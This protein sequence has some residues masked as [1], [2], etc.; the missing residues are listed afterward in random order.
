MRP[1]VLIII[2]SHIIG[3]PG[4]GL[5]Q[6]LKYASPDRFNYVLCN[7]NVANYKGEFEF[8]KQAE[9]NGINIELI[10]QKYMFDPG[11]IWQAYKLIKDNDINIIQTHGYK[12]HII[13]FI[14]SIIL[15]I[16][17][18]A[19]VHG[20]TYE[21]KKIR[22]YNKLELFLLRYPHAVITV[23]PVLYK[24]LV[25]RRGERRTTKMILNAIDEYD[26]RGSITKKNI[27]INNNLSQ[28]DFVIGVFGRLSPEK[29]H[30]YL[31]E[32][33]AIC[34]DKYPEIRLLILGDG[35]EK[36]NLI[37]LTQRHGLDKIVIFCGHKS[38][39]RDYYDAINLLILP[40][41]TE[42]VPNVVLEAMSLCKPVIATDVGGVSE[43]ITDG[44]NGWIIKPGDANAIVNILDKILYAK[45]DI[46]SVGIKARDSLYPKFSTKKR[47]DDIIQIYEETL[48]INNN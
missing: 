20:W 6:L 12:G 9:E 33:L 45:Q 1:N 24:T 26:I 17:W 19:M 10:N 27:R 40:S 39:V 44:F 16:K 23:S 46:V 38:N 31:I 47:A 30:K 36:D 34:T 41:L 25:K 29:G 21:N 7:F 43:I 13:G 2:A 3:G 35:P 15:N 18:I 4:R 37:K 28:N 48:S 11:M 5:F 42:G 14:L 8:K 32:A 22:M